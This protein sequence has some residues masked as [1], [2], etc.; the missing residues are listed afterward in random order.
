MKNV[1][2]C[3]APLNKDHFWAGLHSISFFSFGN[4]RSSFWLNVPEGEKTLVTNPMSERRLGAR[5]L[6]SLWPALGV[7]SGPFLPTAGSS[8][9][10]S[11]LLLSAAGGPTP[12]KG[13]SCDIHFSFFQ[14]NLLGMLL[15]L[16]A[17]SQAFAAAPKPRMSLEVSTEFLSTV[18]DIIASCF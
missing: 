2:I 9:S 10:L 13:S 3:S 14:V 18:F 16:L 17:T 1:W 15:L 7:L 6:R 8:H 11:A 5:F 4:F 12:F